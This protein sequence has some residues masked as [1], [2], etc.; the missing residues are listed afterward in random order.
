MSTVVTSYT[1]P[2]ASSPTVIVDSHMVEPGGTA[3]FAGPGVTVVNHDS[4]CGGA[5]P[6]PTLPP[7]IDS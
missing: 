7:R 3:R 4:R 6:A 5:V 2:T 1:D